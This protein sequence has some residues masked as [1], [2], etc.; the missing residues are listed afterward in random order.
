MK[1]TALVVQRSAAA[2]FCALTKPRLS[3]FV[4]IVV[5]L[6]GYL[7]APAELWTILIA[8]VGT[9]RTGKALPALNLW[10]FRLVSGVLTNTTWWRDELI[11]C[12]I[13]PAKIAVVPNGLAHTWNGKWRAVRVRVPG[14]D[15]EVVTRRGYYAP[16]DRKKARTETR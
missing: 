7:A 9:V 13:D 6:S 4:L 11:R 14:R 5:F 15:L 1:A 3:T 10:S 12:G 2:D 16:N 8:V